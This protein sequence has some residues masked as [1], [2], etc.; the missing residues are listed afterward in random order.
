MRQLTRCFWSLVITVAF[1][2]STIAENWPG[3][4]GP[5]GDGTC[6]EKGLSTTWST[7]ENV[8]WKIALPERGNSTP[9]VWGDR[10]FVTQAIEKENREAAVT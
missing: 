5:R 10:V 2:S 1:S 9:V 3:W 7:T 8:A 6:T 4:R